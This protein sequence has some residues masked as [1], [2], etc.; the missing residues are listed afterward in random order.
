MALIYLGRISST[1]A[2]PSRPF[3]RTT[4]ISILRFAGFGTALFL[5]PWP[6]LLAYVCAVNAA[7]SAIG[8]ALAI[9]GFTDI[10]E[11][12]LTEKGKIVFLRRDIIGILAWLLCA[13]IC[14]W[15]AG[16]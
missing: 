3:A 2:G 15:F 8:A 16:F 13:A 12:M 10:P 11:E 4:M 6:S 14:A 9:A 1:V 7:S 5:K